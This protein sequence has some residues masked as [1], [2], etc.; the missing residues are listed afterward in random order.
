M[1]PP[2]GTATVGRSVC[3]CWE[4]SKPKGPKEASQRPPPL[5]PSGSSSSQHRRRPE[6]VLQK[7]HASF[8][9]TFR[10]EAPPPRPRRARP[11]GGPNGSKSCPEAG[12]EDLCIFFGLGKK[13]SSRARQQARMGAPHIFQ[14]YHPGGNP[15]AN[16]NF[17]S[18]LLYKCLLGEVA[19]VGD[20][21]RICPQLDSR[22]VQLH[23]V[24]AERRRL[25]ICFA[26]PLHA[27]VTNLRLFRS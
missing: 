2:R 1:V 23:F 9:I 20:W 19:S 25:V 18:Q 14:V 5:G 26:H 7:S 12:H 27:L 17:F 10:L 13:L 11:R 22:V 6:L 16:G 15:G 3:L 4:H 8:R 24:P 21:F